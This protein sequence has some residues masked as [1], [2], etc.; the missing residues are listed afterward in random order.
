MIFLKYIFIPFLILGTTAHAQQTPGNVQ[1]ETITIVGAT[2]HL[3]NGQVIENSVL[4]F[5][6]GKLVTVTEKTTYSGTLSGANVIDA[7]GKH[8]YPGFIA[9]NSTLGLVEVDA[10]RASDDQQEMGQMLP[11]IRSLIAYNAESKVVESMRPNGVLLAQSTPQGGRIS[12]TSSVVQLD[13]WNWEDAAVK[14]YDGIHLNWPRTLS[15]NRNWETRS[16]SLES[17]K[18]YAKEV[19]E[20]EQFFEDSKAY[21]EGN[22]SPVNLPFQAMSGLF[23]GKQNLYVHVN[24][25]KGITDAVGFAKKH[26][27]KLVLVDAEEAYKL[28]DLL[29]NEG[30]GVLLSNTHR[31]PGSQDQDYDMPYKLPKLL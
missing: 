18:D 20:I 2:A 16:W 30:V 28:T 21:L 24:D 12:G 1:S 19:R 4:V 15:Y 22:R 6:K 10:V 25:E 27:L 5:D 31:L 23:E 29:K 11:H 7:S 26:Q 13:A 8:V 3:G 9:A 17:N 14:S